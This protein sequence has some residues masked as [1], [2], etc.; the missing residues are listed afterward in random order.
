MLSFAY[1]R[2]DGKVPEPG[3]LD[4]E[5]RDLLAK[6]EAGFETVGA[7]YDAC[8]FRAAPRF[9]EGMPGRGDGAGPGGQRLSRPQGALVPDQGGPAGGGDERLRHAKRARGGQPEDH[10]GA[11]A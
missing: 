10:P 5:D 7:L 2:F 1:K 8:K 9:P 6:V 11:D 4:A 3:P